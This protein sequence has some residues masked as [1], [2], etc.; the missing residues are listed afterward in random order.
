MRTSDQIN[1]IRI[2]RI[3]LIADE[4]EE[5]RRTVG[6][7]VYQA[8]VDIL[9]ASKD[10]RFQEVNEHRRR[11]LPSIPISSGSSVPPIGIVNVPC[12]ASGVGC[13]RTV[14]YGLRARSRRER[15]T[16][17]RLWPT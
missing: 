17:G 16:P 13:W 8:M 15:R 2:A 7:V 9:K 6:E 12:Q 10:D 5:Y 14:C 1:A 11:T 4:P 3:D